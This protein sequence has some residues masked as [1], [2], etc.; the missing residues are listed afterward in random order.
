MKKTLVIIVLVLVAIQFIRI[1]KTNLPV[2]PKQDY[3]NV[4]QAPEDVKVILK[5]ACYDCHSNEVKYPWYTNIAP[6]SWYVKGHINE[7]REHVNFSEFG[8]YNKYQKEH[9]LGDLPET[10]QK[11]NMPLDSYLWIHKEAALS[12]KDQKVLTEWFETFLPKDS[13]G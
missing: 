4:T 11:G 7:G 8:K 2:D 13:K 1:D 12:Q 9:I 5:K 10:I 6:I 3:V